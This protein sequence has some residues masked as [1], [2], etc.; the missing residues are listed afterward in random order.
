MISHR[1]ACSLYFQWLFI[2]IGEMLHMSTALLANEPRSQQ[3]SNR[4]GDAPV[5]SSCYEGRRQFSMREGAN[6]RSRHPC[7]RG[8]RWLLKRVLNQRTRAMPKAGWG[9]VI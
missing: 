3:Y 7:F 4:S 5:H 9:V 1:F 2:V 8:R 6:R